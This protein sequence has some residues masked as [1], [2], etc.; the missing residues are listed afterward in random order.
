M[1]LVS[2]NREQKEKEQR[3]RRGLPS[4]SEDEDDDMDMKNGDPFKRYSKSEL[5]K[6]VPSYTVYM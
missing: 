4:E 1:F 5:D 2:S 6:K 3:R